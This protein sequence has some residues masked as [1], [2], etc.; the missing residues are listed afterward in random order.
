MKYIF[1][2]I[3]C[4]FVVLIKEATKMLWHYVAQEK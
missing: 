1:C 4:Y 2:L 3:V